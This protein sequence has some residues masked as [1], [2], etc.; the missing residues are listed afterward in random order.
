VFGAE[1]ISTL[2]ERGLES[3]NCEVVIS[4]AGRQFFF[5]HLHAEEHGKTIGSRILEH[6]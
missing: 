4:E 2:E 1:A 6:I 5:P 3:E